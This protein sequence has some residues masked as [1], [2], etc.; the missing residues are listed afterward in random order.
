MQRN[1]KLLSCLALLFQSSIADKCN[2]I[3]SKDTAGL[4]NMACCDPDALTQQCL[5]TSICNTHAVCCANPAEHLGY[6][7]NRQ[8]AQTG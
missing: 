6:L 5:F 4:P 3:S 7:S 8:M 1:I 2:V